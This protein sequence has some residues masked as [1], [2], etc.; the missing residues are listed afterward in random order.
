MPAH[1]SPMPAQDSP[2][3]DLLTALR[4]QPP[5][6]VLP[7]DGC[8]R[9]GETDVDHLLIDP[10]TEEHVDCASCGHRYELRYGAPPEGSQRAVDQ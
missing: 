4:A 1:D 8:P 2:I 5:N 10:E 6:H 9:C 3:D 7:A